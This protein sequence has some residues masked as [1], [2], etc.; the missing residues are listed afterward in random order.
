VL[1]DGK[2]AAEMYGRY[3]RSTAPDVRDDLRALAA[4]RADELR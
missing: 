4:K 1:G 2:K 3:A